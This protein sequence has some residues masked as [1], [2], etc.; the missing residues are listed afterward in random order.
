[1]PCLS[2]SYRVRHASSLGGLL[3]LTMLTKVDKNF[4]DGAVILCP[5]VQIH[6]T[7]RP[8]LAVE[9]VGK[10]LRSLAPKIPFAR[11]NRGLNSSSE[12]AAAV[13][14]MK[15]ADPLFYNGR[16][17]IGTGLAILDAI[18]YVQDKFHLIETPYL[19]QHG[20]ADVVCHISG[21]EEL[22]KKTR[23]VDKQFR[24][25]PN[26]SHD[27]SNEPPSIRDAV[28]NDFVAW[29]ETQAAKTS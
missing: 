23:S 5:A 25:Y 1:M 2:L 26:A 27:L 11:G 15:R 18:E 7:S 29:L 3:I 9:T 22:H 17:R 10:M 16:L 12:V 20:L 13:D 14:A 19:L 28:V 4:V 8:S 6:A 21:S 24:S